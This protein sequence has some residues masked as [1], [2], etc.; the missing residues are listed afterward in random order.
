MVKK[1][2]QEI[3]NFEDL[4]GRK[5]C[6]TGYGRTAGWNVPVAMLI[7]RGLIRPQNC[8]IPQGVQLVSVCVQLTA[9]TRL[10]SI[11]QAFLICSFPHFVAIGEYFS[12]SCVPGANQPGF[13]A[14]LCALCVG[15]SAEQNKCEKGKD[16]YDG[17]DG[18]FR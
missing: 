18:A 4:R 3:R 7:E 12:Q 14:S 5:S 17:Y 1:S 2:N 8:Q 13:P 10:Q 16:R 15:D 6:H 11:F 9:G